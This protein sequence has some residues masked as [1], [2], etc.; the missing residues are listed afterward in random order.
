MTLQTLGLGDPRRQCQHLEVDTR[1]PHSWDN[2]LAH[3]LGI[4]VV[5]V[6]QAQE[7]ADIFESCARES[8]TE[9]S[10]DGEVRTLEDIFEDFVG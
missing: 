7:E 1:F 2:N 5:T 4:G 9:K 10:W 3:V 8:E 6:L